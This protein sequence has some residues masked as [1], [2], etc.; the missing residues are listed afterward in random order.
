M[1]LVLIVVLVSLLAACADSHELLRSSREIPKLDRNKTMYV[2]V[3]ED[4]R[5]GGTVYTG[6]GE[7]TAQI[8]VLAFSQY[9]SRVESGHEYQK[10]D[11]ALDAARKQGCAY[12]AVSTILEWE[13][14]RTEWS[15]IPDRA[16]VKIS[17]VD[18]ENKRTID[19]VIIKGKSGLATFGGDHPQDLLPKPVGQYAKSLFE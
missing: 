1:R 9:V 11:D 16:S 17:I 2:A 4:G 5:Y 7:N 15:G 13:D 14:R 18:M 10:F 8:L 19:S 6:S 3:P 12:L